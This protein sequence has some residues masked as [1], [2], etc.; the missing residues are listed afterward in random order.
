MTVR[1]ES[2]LDPT[3]L[4]AALDLTG[5]SAYFFGIDALPS[6]RRRKPEVRRCPNIRESIYNPL[7][8]D[9]ES[10]PFEGQGTADQY[11]VGD[12]SGKFCSLPPGRSKLQLRL[13]DHNLPLF[14]ARSVLGRALV[15]YEPDG[16]AAACANIELDNEPMN[17]AYATFDQPVQGQFIFRQSAL[18]C[19]QQVHVYVEISKPDTLNALRSDNHAWHVHERAVK[20]GKLFTFLTLICES[21]LINFVYLQVSTL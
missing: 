1:Q 9:G 10:V 5:G 2:S 3:E 20:A 18:D 16:A 14:G 7:H 21:L 4:H 17:T 11:A 12:L 6:I 19:E 8:V 15:L 13:L